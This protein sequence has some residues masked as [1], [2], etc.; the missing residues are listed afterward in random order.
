[1]DVGVQALGRAS[2]RL[3]LDRA[4]ESTLERI[5]I[6]QGSLSYKD[7]RL[8]G[9][10]A[11][12]VVEVIEHLDLSRLEA[13]ERVLF[14]FAKPKFIV[15]TTP[16]KEY[17]ASY[18]MPD[19]QLRHS[20]HRFEWTRAE[21]RDWALKTAERFGYDVQFSEVGDLDEAVGRPT[22]MGVFRCR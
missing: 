13:F 19:S 6:F 15:I 7:S 5:K 1:M 4:S 22:Q 21:F 3:K 9:Y 14:E 18:F 10:D 16:N 12:A 8:S 11:A 20:D 2:Y 17:N